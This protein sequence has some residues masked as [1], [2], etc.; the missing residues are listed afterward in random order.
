MQIMFPVFSFGAFVNSNAYYMSLIWANVH[1][2]ENTGNIICIN[3]FSDFSIK[4]HK[5]ENTITMLEIIREDEN[6]FYSDFID[7]YNSMT[8]QELIDAINKIKNIK[9]F[10]IT[11][12]K[13][14][15]IDFSNFLKEFEENN[16]LISFKRVGFIE[17]GVFSEEAKKLYPRFVNIISPRFGE[18]QYYN[19]ALS[20]SSKNIEGIQYIGCES[21]SMSFNF[22]NKALTQITSSLWASD[23]HTL[24]KDSILKEERAEERDIVM[25]Q[26]SKYPT[27]LFIN[28]TEATSVSDIAIAFEWTK[29]EK[30]NVSAKRVKGEGLSNDLIERIMADD[31][32][33]LT[34]EEILDIIDPLKF[35]GRAPSQVVEFIDEYV[36]PIID[37]NKD[38][39]E[40]KSEINV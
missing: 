8:Q 19:L 39:L 7:I 13:N 6:G 1:T 2:K 24:D 17:S 37:E 22:A 23:E 18:T 35:I 28:G 30:F 25:A 16:Y 40:I 20:D 33:K 31:Y 34:K 9:A 38:A 4:M 14:D 3:C 32:F 21:K 27:K 15:K 10:L 5:N 11:G 36:T 26:T 29:E 12:D